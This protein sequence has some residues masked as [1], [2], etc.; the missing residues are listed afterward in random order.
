MLRNVLA[1]LYARKSSAD[2]GKPVERQE[3]AWRADCA[4]LE[5]GPGRVFV[6]PDFSAS[7]YAK[8]ARPDYLALLEH[9]RARQCEMVCMWETSRGSRVPALSLPG[10]SRGVARMAIEICALGDSPR[11]AELHQV[12]RPQP[13]SLG[14]RPH[15]GRRPLED[16]RGRLG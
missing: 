7:R 1:D 6:D 15:L 8:R 4:D 10:R 2:G 12:L 14:G 13:Q 9:I 16:G 5:V 3:R 11:D